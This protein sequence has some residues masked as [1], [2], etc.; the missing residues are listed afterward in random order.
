MSLATFDTLYTLFVTSV[1]KTWLN[2]KVVFLLFD[3]CLG[4]C[5][6]RVILLPGPSPSLSSVDSI[7]AI[8]RVR[9]MPNRYS[10]LTVSTAQT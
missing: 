4:A 3:F 10:L 8:L 2:N 9:G 5:Q 7:H 1:Q 6:G